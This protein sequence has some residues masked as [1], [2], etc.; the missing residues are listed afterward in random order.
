M[1]I[2]NGGGKIPKQGCAKM[3]MIGRH[4]CSL[5]RKFKYFAV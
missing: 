3:A 2:V 5:A 4:I 1:A